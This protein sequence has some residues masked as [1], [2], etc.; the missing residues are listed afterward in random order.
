MDTLIA[1]PESDHPEL[2]S[3][4]EAERNFSLTPEQIQ[5]LREHVRIR[6]AGT[7]HGRTHHPD[8]EFRKIIAPSP[9]EYDGVKNE[10]SKLDAANGDVLFVEQ[11]AHID[12]VMKILRR[13]R[14]K[15]PAHE[16]EWEQQVMLDLQYFNTLDYAAVVAAANDIPVVAADIE[17]ERYKIFEDDHKR[18]TGMSIEE[19]L[20]TLTAE[21][22]EIPNELH[23][24]REQLVMIT[25]IQHAL[26]NMQNILDSG[27]KP[28]YLVVFGMGHIVDA[29]EYSK[30]GLDLPGAFRKVGVE[31]EVTVLP[32][33]SPARDEKIKNYLIKR[34]M[35]NVIKAIFDEIDGAK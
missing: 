33:D 6:I 5:F 3:L 22:L 11:P 8:E 1:A 17:H 16:E 15:L 10:V 19:A 2:P 23:T 14:R 32:H 13:P 21:N 25:V 24:I 18:R 28:T 29:N 20:D 35:R 26:D 12:K 30:E 4:T 9:L 34:K 7:V 27:K 31:P